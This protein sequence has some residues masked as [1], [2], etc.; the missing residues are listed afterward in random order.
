MDNNEE[1]VGPIGWAIGASVIR[2][3][4]SGRV[5]SRD[6]LAE[7]LEY[8]GRTTTNILEKAA[9]QDAAGFVRQGK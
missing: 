2:L 9:Y 4:A 6:N 7:D 3:I 1:R 5:I 8:A